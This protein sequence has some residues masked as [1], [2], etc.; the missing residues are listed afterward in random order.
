MDWS[1]N[2]NISKEKEIN[3]DKAEKITK[4]KWVNYSQ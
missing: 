3:E 2:S 4:N 1:Q